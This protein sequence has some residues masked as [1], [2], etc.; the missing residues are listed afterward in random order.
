MVLARIYLEFFRAPA[1]SKEAPH[2]YVTAI[3]DN[4]AAIGYAIY[5]GVAATCTVEGIAGMKEM[6][7]QYANGLFYFLH[8]GG[9]S[10]LNALLLFGLCSE[11]D[12]VAGVFKHWSLVYIGSISY[13]QYIMQA[14][15]FHLVHAAYEAAIYKDS[16]YTNGV[17]SPVPAGIEPGDYLKKPYGPW[18]FQLV[19][20]GSL[21]ATAFLTHYFISVPVGA[22][23]RKK[24]DAFCDGPLLA[25]Q[26]TPRYGSM[27][28]AK[29][30]PVKPTK[31][32][33][34]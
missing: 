6:N 13:A 11:G 9:M 12:A 15:V 31:T 21:F 27:V 22:H 3:A 29:L 17:Q 14:I 19:L 23:L 4:G 24:L 20:P 26:S 7:D 33:P 28:T 8:N 25:A 32:L 16:I 34:V 2:P 18:Q 30:G 1:G 5:F 10:P